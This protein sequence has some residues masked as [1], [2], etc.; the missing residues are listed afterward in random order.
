MR[1]FSHRF[2]FRKFVC[3]WL[4]DCNI[5]YK[6]EEILGLYYIL[7]KMGKRCFNWKSLEIIWKN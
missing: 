4:Q 5:A 3:S 7:D 2:Y 6:S 1:F